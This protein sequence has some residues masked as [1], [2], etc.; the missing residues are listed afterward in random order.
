VTVN[1]AAGNAV[2]FIDSLKVALSA[3]LADIPVAVFTGITDTTVG[4]GT[5]VVKVHT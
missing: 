3:W 5:I 2:Q 4:A 1:A